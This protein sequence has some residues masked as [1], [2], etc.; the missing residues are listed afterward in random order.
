METRQTPTVHT[1]AHVA[2]SIIYNNRE[3][4]LASIM[5]A[6]WDELKGGQVRALMPAFHTFIF[7]R[8]YLTTR[9]VI[10]KLLY[11]S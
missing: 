3:N 2:K 10:Y 5:V 1:A 11:A 7:H 6:G 9:N 8:I 4:L